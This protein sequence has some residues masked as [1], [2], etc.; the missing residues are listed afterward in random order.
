MIGAEAAVIITCASFSAVALTINISLLI[1]MKKYTP[2]SFANFGIV[3]KFQVL[4]D[5]HTNFTAAAVINRTILLSDSFVY[6]AHG[7]C[8]LLSSSVCFA[9]YGIALLGGLMSIYIVLVSFIVRLQIM[10]NRNPSNRSIVALLIVLPLPVPAAITL[11][12]NAP[13]FNAMQML[14]FNSR[15]DDSIMREILYERIPE[16]VATDATIFGIE[17][18]RIATMRLS[19]TLIIVFIMPI[20]FI[21]LLLR[22]KIVKCLDN[23]GKCIS[24]KTRKMHVQFV[25]MLTLQ[26]VIPPIVFFATFVPIELEYLDLLRHPMTEALINILARLSTLLS[27]IVVFIH[28]I[29]YKWALFRWIGSRYKQSRSSVNANEEIALIVLTA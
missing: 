22:S 27:P 13:V 2:K 26:C 11:K 3:M 16:Y 15:S 17:D 5:I 14:F 28:I 1:I 29:P 12:E 9:S 20:Y 25:K 4:V 10:S 18:I 6:I 7:P 19:I 24:D 8:T 21:L 23:T